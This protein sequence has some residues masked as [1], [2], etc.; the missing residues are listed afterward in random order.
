MPDRW[1]EPPAA[2][3]SAWPTLPVQEWRATRTHV[4][5]TSQLLGKVRLALGPWLNH[6]WGTTLHVSPRGLT[7]GLMPYGAAGVELELDLHDGHIRGRTSTG[8]DA[9]FAASERSVAACFT[10]LS[11]LLDTL[12]TPTPISVMPSEIVDAVPFDQVHEPAG[13]DLEHARA[14]HQALVSTHRVMSRFRADYLGKVSPV[15][16]FWGSFDLAVTRFSGRPAPEHPAGIPGLP[17]DVA[18]EA[19]SHEVSSAGFWPG[20]AQAPAAI[21]YSYAYPEPAGFAQARVRPADA[22]YAASLGE[23]VLPYD[24]VAAA[25]DP[26]ATLLAFFESTYAAAAD[27][28]GWDRVSLEHPEPHR[29]T[30]WHR[31][32]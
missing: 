28:G 17:D 29:G 9:S 1:P 30:W 15:H 10:A 14:L 5:L 19:Y 24:A 32:G 23:F 13:F 26:D 21:F 22:A 8:R 18:K 7:T 25:E 16:F 6:S 2:P 11:G 4:H 20:D 31:R 27:L 3:A 12:G